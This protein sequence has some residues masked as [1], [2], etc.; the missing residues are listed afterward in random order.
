MGIKMDANEFLQRE[1]S[2]LSMGNSWLYY[3]DNG[4]WVVLR[5][6]YGKKHND[7]LYSG[8]NQNEAL[9]ALKHS[10]DND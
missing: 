1:N 3:S 7:T 9:M 5:H 2:R 8:N 4:E 10:E 6:G